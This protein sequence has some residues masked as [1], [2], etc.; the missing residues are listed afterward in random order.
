MDFEIQCNLDD[1]SMNQKDYADYV[2]WVLVQE[3]VGVQTRNTLAK[4]AVLKMTAI[5]YRIA[6]EIVH[7]LFIEEC[8]EDIYKSLPKKYQW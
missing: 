6:G 7:A 5:Q 4:F 3:S 8:M 1:M 2:Q